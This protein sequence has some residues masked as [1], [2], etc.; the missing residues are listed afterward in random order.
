MFFPPFIR[1]LSISVIPKTS[2]ISSLRF[3]TASLGDKFYALLHKNPKNVEAVLNCSKAK[4]DVKCIN[5]VLKRCA[6]DNSLMGLRFFI[7]AGSQAGYRHSSYMYSKACECFR[8]KKSPKVV[9]DLFE[10]YRVE[11]CVVT[12]K[13]FKVVLNLCREGSLVDEALMVLRKMPQFNIRADT[14][15]YNVVIKLLCDDGKMDDAQKLMGEMGL[16]DLYPDIITYMSMIKGFCKVGLL[17]EACELLKVMRGHGCVPN[18]V[19]YS[20]IVDGVCKF[21]SPE[22]AIELLGEMEKEGGDCNPNVV[23]YTSVIQSFSEKGRTRDALG[24]LDRMEAYGCAPNRVTVSYLI[25]GICMH[26]CLEEACKLIDRVVVGG[27]VSYGDCYSSLVICLIKMKKVEEAEKQ[28]WRILAGG[29]KLDS[30]ACSLMIKE[31]CLEK[32]MLDAFRLHEEMQKMGW[33]F[34]IDSGV[35]S[36]LLNGLSQQNHLKEASSIASL[37]LEKGICLRISY[38]DKI[39]GIL[40]NL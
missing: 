27:S 13:T 17:E 3:T 30:L 18:V 20:T 4:L 29:L 28:F 40:E 36:M 16:I 33:L 10:A 35:Y 7:W 25:Q 11:K 1:F 8:I 14:N 5:E 15:S 24:I 37:C 26:N 6:V 22:R 38:L 39:N 34:S 2:N 32:R 23:T 12:V 21:G 9:V 19:V 31:L